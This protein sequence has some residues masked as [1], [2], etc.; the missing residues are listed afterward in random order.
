MHS[1]H[2]TNAHGQVDRCEEVGGEFWLNL[3]PLW[4]R[5]SYCPFC[6]TPAPKPIGSTVMPVEPQEEIDVDGIVDE[7]RGISYIGKAIK[8][9]NGKYW[10]LAGGP[11]GLARVEVS[12]SVPPSP[13]LWEGDN[14]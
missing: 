6:G 5:V 10:C 14:A 4:K 13:K 7:K 9:T 3:V 11:F 12:I 2:Q 8:M 1:C